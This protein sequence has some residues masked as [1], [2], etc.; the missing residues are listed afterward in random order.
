MEEVSNIMVRLRELTVQSASDTVG[1][2]E[3]G[4]LDMEYQQLITEVDRISQ[5]T[6]FNGTSLL[7]GDSG[8]GTLDFQVGAFAGEQNIIQFDSDETDVS[9]SNIGVEGTTISNKDDALESISVVDEAI[10][11]VSGKRANLGSIQSRLQST[12][13]NLE[14]QTLNQDHA[15][16]V[17]QDV[18]VAESTAKLASNNVV[19]AAA[20]STLA[21]ANQIPNGA[22]RLLG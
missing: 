12:V 15:R 10:N 9:S 16:S 13:S 7:G 17:I 20:I 1:D 2:N 21:Q 4:L 19:K 18:D 6:V 8:R 11:S 14:V 3:R 5:S 22:L